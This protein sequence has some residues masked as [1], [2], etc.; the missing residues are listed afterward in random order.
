[1][2]NNL[3]ASIPFLLRKIHNLIRGKWTTKNEFNTNK[4][5]GSMSNNVKELVDNLSYGSFEPVIIKGDS[6]PEIDSMQ[7]AMSMAQDDINDIEQEGNS[8]SNLALQLNT[9]IQSSTVGVLNKIGIIGSWMTLPDIENSSSKILV[10]TDKF[11]NDALASSKS[12]TYMFNGKMTLGTFELGNILEGNIESIEV[13]SNGDAGNAYEIKPPVGVI[14]VNDTSNNNSILEETTAEF[15]SDSESS[16]NDTNSIVNGDKFFELSCIDLLDYNV[17]VNVLSP[18]NV[19][20]DPIT[21]EPLVYGDAIELNR[22]NIDASTKYVN[23]FEYTGAKDI[24]GEWEISNPHGYGWEYERQNQEVDDNVSLWIGSPGSRNVMDIN[25]DVI[26]RSD[27]KSSD[28]LYATIIINIKEPVFANEVM[29]KLEDIKRETG[30]YILPTLDQSTNTPISVL[31]DKGWITANPYSSVSLYNNIIAASFTYNKIYAIKVMLQQPHYYRT[32]LGHPYIKQD[33]TF[34]V[35]T[36]KKNK[37]FGIAY[38]TNKNSEDYHFIIRYPTGKSKR[39]KRF[40]IYNSIASYY[41]RS[42]PL[43]GGILGFLTGGILGRNFGFSKT[44]KV[45]LTNWD[46]EDAKII[47]GI[48]PFL[49]KR[50]AIRIGSIGVFEPIYNSKD[51][52]E[53]LPIES[54]ADIKSIYL[55]VDEGVIPKG[56]NI[57]YF[58]RIPGINTDL[59]ITPRNITRDSNLVTKYVFDSTKNTNE[60]TKYIEVDDPIRSVILKIQMTRGDDQLESPVLH[61]YKLYLEV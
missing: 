39:G 41:D 25:D 50:W 28:I 51:T 60:R 45:E 26:T 1:M 19:F 21:G 36:S 40:N 61:Q 4:A 7:Q 24:N 2:K 55:E 42:Y 9:L 49:A 30:G 34:T 35:E 29:I 12:S 6:L 5:I 47:Y 31:T 59:P 53:S 14:S 43:S 16:S 22:G 8:V 17:P 33:I 44:T 56:C 10:F 52:Y 57:N 38:K 15:W 27:Y 23:L 20:K 3:N 32:Y 13:L 18:F 48:E 37:G 11:D 54:Y 58:I 46:S